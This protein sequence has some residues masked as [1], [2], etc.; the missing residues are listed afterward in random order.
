MVLGCLS[1][2]LQFFMR[3]KQ[4]IEKPNVLVNIQYGAMGA[5]VILSAYSQISSSLESA[6]ARRASLEIEVLS[7]ISGLYIPVLDGVTAIHANMLTVRHY[8]SYERAK[9]EHPEFAHALDWHSDAADSHKAELKVAQDSLREI[10]VA[11]AKIVQIGVEH[12]DLV[13]PET[14]E[15]AAR[16]LDIRL[17][18]VDQYLDP[19]VPEGEPP[20]ESVLAYHESL[21]LAFRAA[22]ERIRI[23]S[24]KLRKI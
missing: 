9:N 1:L 19:F 2:A 15:W 5:I 21:G 24:A 8:L 23:A 4:E 12:G 14:V 13:P 18:N 20:S 3:K 7:N 10:Q 22:V 11:A 17:A 16:T 6:E